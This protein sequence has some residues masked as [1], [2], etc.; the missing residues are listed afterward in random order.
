V[1]APRIEAAVT[2]GILGRL[3]AAIPETLFLLVAT[4]AGLWAGGRWLD[5]SGDPG[6]WW[7]LAER[8]AKG[9]RYYR[10]VFLQ[11]GPLSPYVFS[12]SGRPFGFSAI[13]F[14]LANWIPAIAAGLLLLRLARPH[15]NGVERSVLVGWM[16]AVALFAPGPARLVLSY[17]PAAIHAICFA[18]G[19][20]LILPGWQAHPR[21]A[22]WAGILA[23]LAFCAKQEI[24]VTT[25]L[26][27]SAPVLVGPRRARAWIVRC[28]GGFLA[29]ALVGG[30]F[31]LASGASVA[32]LRQDS[33]VWP[34][35]LAPPPEWRAVFRLVAGLA[36]FD[37]SEALILRFR[38]LVQ[39]AALLALVGLMLGRERL[40]RRW[41][42]AAALLL[43]LSMWN[44]IEGR[45]L[46]LSIN[47]VSL[48]VAACLLVLLRAL[49]QRHLPGRDL[50]MA[51][52]FFGAV[53]G[54]RTLV[55]EDIV[56]PYSGIAHFATVLPWLLL[57][58]RIL[59]ELLPGG[60]TPA[61]WARWAWALLLLVFA[62]RG[63]WTGIQSLR[64]PSRSAVETPR[65]RIWVQEPQPAVLRLLARELH[66][67]ESVLFVP[68]TNAVDVLLGIRDASPYLIHLP[69]WLSARA[70]TSLID[71]FERNPPDAVV[72][73]DRTTGEFGVKP[74]GMGF[75]RRLAD[76]ISRN[77]RV[78][79]ATPGAKVLRRSREPEASALLEHES[80]LARDEWHGGF[81]QPLDA[82]KEGKRPG[83][84]DPS[85]PDA[86]RQKIEK[87][88]VVPRRAQRQVG[89]FPIEAV[90]VPLEDDP[91]LRNVGAG[92][93]PDGLEAPLPHGFVIGLGRK[94][95]VKLSPEG[96]VSGL[97]QNETSSPSQHPRG[98]SKEGT[99]IRQMMEDV[100]HQDGRDR[101][102]GEGDRL[103]GH[104]AVEMGF[105]IEIG[106]EGVWKDL[107]EEASAGP[108]LDHGTFGDPSQPSRQFPVVLP[109]ECLEKR[110]LLN[111]LSMDLNQLRRIVVNPSDLGKLEAA[112]EPLGESADHRSS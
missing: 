102:V 47:P 44:L 37:W 83:R 17:C 53:V 70:E 19:A 14:L 27:L 35:A 81:E 105:R 59:P 77:Y 94:Q 43:S 33:H 3:R 80:R 75:G 42:T 65:G 76:W 64:D 23:G 104:D 107:L 87:G 22:W 71:R 9:E 61:V 49:F 28:A 55:A 68:Q 8:I 38:G 97:D 101:L 7:S 112:L 4:A 34:L 16:T 99:R 48:S 58:C 26:A 93:T 100:E 5:P 95:A 15:L 108:E 52:A 86:S 74:F 40:G 72:L 54:T 29:V 89:E 98:L 41:A 20:L 46:V 12:F 111:R 92:E 73:F 13:W 90:P 56:G 110:L 106:R 2:F 67:G 103:G 1:S 109:I 62:W 63:A 45:S 78:A 66:P 24:G 31:V 6:I 18:L 30:L 21:R 11:Y 57:L 50:W 84:N 69:G 25:L 88:R 91:R 82:E 85:K 51:L 39:W 79:P 60:G 36:A 32:S 10:D 96:S